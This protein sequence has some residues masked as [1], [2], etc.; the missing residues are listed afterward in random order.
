MYVIDTVKNEVDVIS[1][2]QDIYFKEEK[3]KVHVYK[4]STHIIFLENAMKRGKKVPR[5][6][7]YHEEEG[8]VLKFMRRIREVLRAVYNMRDEL[9][10]MVNEMEQYDTRVIE[11]ASQDVSVTC[12]RGVD[13]FSPFHKVKPL[14]DMPAKWTISHFIKG[15]LSGQIYDCTIRSIYTDDYAHDSD[16]NYHKGE[17]VDTLEFVQQLVEMPGGWWISHLSDTG[18]V[19]ISCHHFDRRTAKVD[20]GRVEPVTPVDT[21]II[22]TDEG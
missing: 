13:V 7:V 2:Y 8:E 1:K 22:I 14:K 19:D 12:Y 21:T 17:A 16:V 18:E 3:I 6:A 4:G 15:M 5:L 10:R 11:I 9:H 20:I